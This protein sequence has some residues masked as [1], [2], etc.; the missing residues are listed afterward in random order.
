LFTASAA[1][2]SLLQDRRDIT[3]A[4]A[5][6]SGTAKFNITS[7]LLSSTSIGGQYYRKKTRL[8]QVTGREFPA[9]GLK[10]AAAAAIRDGQQDFYINTT[11]GLYAQEQ[12][13][14]TTGC[15]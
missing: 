14:G 10:T 7:G 2:G 11:I 1:K 5:D 3:F 6:Y 4:S 12:S 15:S 9:P 8:G 13:D